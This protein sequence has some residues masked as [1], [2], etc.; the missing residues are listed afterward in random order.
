MSRRAAALLPDGWRDEGRLGAFDTWLRE[1]GNV[2][3]P[4]TT[5]DLVAA[6]LFAGLREGVIAAEQPFPD[7]RSQH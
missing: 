2:R 4:G 7:G 6:C 1:E 5:A 3:N